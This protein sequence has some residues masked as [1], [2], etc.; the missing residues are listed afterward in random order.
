MGHAS[1]ASSLD[2]GW[3][4]FMGS[5]SASM[6]ARTRVWVCSF[7]NQCEQASPVCMLSVQMEAWGYAGGE[8]ACLQ[9]SEW[10]HV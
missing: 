8:C 3:W 9:A 2:Q 7:V 5:V 4:A 6:L 1:Q 10:Q